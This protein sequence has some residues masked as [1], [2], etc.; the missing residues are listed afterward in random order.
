[1]TILKDSPGAG[2]FILSEAGGYRSRQRIVVGASQTLLSGRILAAIGLGALTATPAASTGPG[3]GAVGA[4]TADASAPSGRWL[5]RLLGTGATAAF[6]VRR[7]DGS[8]D[9]QG[10]VGTA[11]NGGINGTLADGA[12]D[13][14]IGA[15]IPVVVA[16]AD[17]EVFVAH[18]PAGTN[19]SQYPRGVLFDDAVT[20]VG[21]SLDAVALVRDCE[22]SEYDL[23]W[24]AHSAPQKAAAIASL[25]ALGVIARH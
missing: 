21:E 10:A 16:Y 18:D 4:W 7:P 3:D 22:V 12:T 2:H 17:G 13:W 14:A 11:Y 25:A 1:M 19:G 20:G 8:F 24:G 9:G 15:E 6:E 23:V 5:I